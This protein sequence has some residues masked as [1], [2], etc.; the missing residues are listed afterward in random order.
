M[1][2]QITSL[3]RWAQRFLRLICPENL[4]EEI[5][6]DL[7]QRFN[8]DV[9]RIG[10]RKSKIRLSISV[11]LFFRPGI[12]LRKSLRTSSNRFDLFKNDLHVTFRQLRQNTL[13]STLNIIG[14]STSIAVLLMVAQYAGF[15]LT[16]EQ[17]NERA[18]D[19]ARIYTKYYEGNKPSH[20][21][22]LTGYDIGFIL[23]KELPEVAAYTRLMPTDSWFDCALQYNGN[24]GSVIFNE[25]KLFFTDSEFFKLF[26]SRVISG[27]L[28]NALSNPYTVV[29][30]SSAANR[31]FKGDDPIG[32][33]LHL[34]GSFEENDY[35]VTAVIEDLPPNTHL[36]ID[37]F[38]SL[39]SLERKQGIGNS[40]FYT[41]I[42]LA[43]NVNIRTFQRKVELLTKNSSI[44][45]SQQVY[46]SVQPLSDIHLHS[47]LE[48]EMKEGAD[49]VIIYFLIALAIILSVIA[50][51]NYLNLSISRILE[52]SREVAIRKVN[53]A[54]RARIA[55]Q[56]F[57]EAVALNIISIVVGIVLIELAAPVFN[58]LTG[59]EF[60]WK[61]STQ[62]DR[63][64]PIIYIA[65][66][67]MAGIMMAANYPS[68]V[69]A[70][71]NPIHVLKGK[72]MILKRNAAA[73]FLITFQFTCSIILLITVFVV[74]EQYDFM[75]NKVIGIDIEQ[76]LIVKAPVTIDSN[77]QSRFAAF[78][79]ITAT[80]SLVKSISTSTSVPGE[81]VEWTGRVTNSINGAARILHIHVADTGY[82]NTYSVPLLMGRN[83]TASDYPN[84]QFGAKTE[85]VILNQ[86]AL[87]AL[88][89]SSEEDA[90]GRTINWGENKC[91]V[92][93]IV[94]NYH[95]QSLRN[96]YKP[97]L[98]TANSGPLMS[99]KLSDRFAKDFQASIGELERA[100][101][102]Y[103]PGNAFDY[104]YLSDFY[105]NHYKG[106]RNLR[107]VI[108][109]ISC[110]A[111]INSCLGLLGLSAFAA[112][113]K[114]KEMSIRKILGAEWFE[115]IFL[116]SM[117]FIILIS[118]AALIAV[119]LAFAQCTHWLDNYAFHI[120]LS[121]RHFA[122]PITLIALLAIF[123]IASQ[124][125]KIA[126][127]SSVTFL[128]S[129]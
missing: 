37:I 91:I 6:G 60:T 64:N 113:Q 73:N 12:V 103:F 74:H 118:V 67:I 13:F 55:S 1:N 3:P 38:M 43:E 16:F 27:K 28:S 105:H 49:P 62:L 54:S 99:L 78:K 88:G 82:F 85:P 124:C 56:F 98:Y 110:V 18:T 40:D 102:T 32:K 96:G 57:T 20:E 87:D 122:L 2:Q 117:K 100:W 77:Y 48:D 34:K 111:L 112:K 52:R 22:A 121:M 125:L 116:L 46:Y 5:E 65:V 101:K 126:L 26:P 83:F 17:Q 81:N 127:K 39:N 75:Q 44:D 45:I 15:H 10:Y 86:K 11:L 4:Y 63:Q 93:G 128:R 7:I 50:W 47:K 24:D 33:T 8:R 19:I 69:L 53:G 35:T 114:I 109:I 61:G 90:L 76:T 29:L 59:I 107:T 95:Q 123:T 97:I 41:Y 129:E 70:S 42:M 106:D 84:E 25:R 115:I 120:G 72:M 9:D 21:S 30:T 66:F 58:S 71:Y 68:T 104:F 94:A 79:T 51:I 80:S 36:D 89:F 23:K 31:Y 14:L 119:P 108:D 92:V